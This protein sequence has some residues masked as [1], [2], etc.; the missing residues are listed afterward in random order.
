MKSRF[1]RDFLFKVSALCHTLVLRQFQS[2]YPIE[3][4]FRE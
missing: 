4:E 2:V 3:Y 1:I